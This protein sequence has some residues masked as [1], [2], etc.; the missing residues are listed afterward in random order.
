[1]EEKTLMEN[2]G[3]ITDF[4]IC[5]FGPTT[6]AWRENRYFIVDNETY[7]NYVDGYKFSLLHGYI[8]YSGTKDGLN[9]KRLHRIIMKQPVGMQVDH[10]NR[11]RF[12]NRRDNLRVATNQQ[13]QMNTGIR[14][15]NSSGVVGVSWYKRGKKWYAQIQINGEKKHLGYFKEKKDAINAREEAEIKYF[16]EFRAK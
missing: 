15:D 5:E 7:K 3:L 14:S 1:M 11:I 6:K 2:F 4:E 8:H 16:K 13:N 10:I 9:C 12:D